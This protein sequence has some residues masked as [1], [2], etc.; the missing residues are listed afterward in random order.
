[1]CLMK[2]LFECVDEDAV[3]DALCDS[4]NDS[5]SSDLVSKRNTKVFIWKYFGFEPN[6]TGNPLSKNHPKCHLCHV[7]IAMK[8]GNTSNLYSH[9][10]NKHPE[11]YDIIQR[12][13]TNTNRK[14]QSDK[15]EKTQQPSLEATWDKQNY[16]LLLLMSI[17]SLLSQ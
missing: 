9:L 7:E 17:R 14:R 4:L 11:Q 13:A 16:I 1:M 5:G 6:E 3:E 12:A 15:T 10:K 2:M 8:Y